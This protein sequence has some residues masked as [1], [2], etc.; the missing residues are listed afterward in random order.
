MFKL[1]TKRRK[2]HEDYVAELEAKVAAI[3]RSQAASRV[4]AWVMTL[5]SRL[6]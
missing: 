6:S 1:K 5:H 2:A 3:M 4:S